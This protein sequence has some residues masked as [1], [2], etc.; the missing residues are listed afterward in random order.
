MWGRPQREKRLGSHRSMSALP[1]QLVASLARFPN[2]HG[3]CSSGDSPIDRATST[4]ARVGACSFTA[5]IAAHHAW[6]GSVVL[7]A[8]RESR[9]CIPPAS[10]HP[11]RN[12]LMMGGHRWPSP[13]GHVW[14]SL[15]HTSGSWPFKARREPADASIMG[16]RPRNLTLAPGGEPPRTRASVITD[17]SLFTDQQLIIKRDRQREKLDELIMH[18]G[19]SLAVIELLVSLDRDVEQMTD[20]LR[21]R[22]RSQ[23]PSSR[24]LS[25]QLHSC[26][27]GWPPHA[28]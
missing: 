19:S 25:A 24:G 22:A 18:P 9:T 7:L 15:L 6:S 1:S 17:F 11:M 8:L 3:R 12:R 21:R 14:E 13:C 4:S 26:S 28:D 5:F 16:T 20:E 23:H 27:P 2:R 10:S